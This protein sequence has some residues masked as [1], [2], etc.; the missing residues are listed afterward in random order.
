MESTKYFRAMSDETR[1][2]LLLLLAQRPLCVCQMQEILELPQS[3]ISKHL[4]KLRD[5]NILQS[6]HDGK[7]VKYELQDDHFLKELLV[8]AEKELMAQ[9]PFT[10]DRERINDF[11]HLV[12]VANRVA[13]NQ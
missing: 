8:L 1:L 2:R 11:D 12:E 13:N 5:Q 4:A 9:P 7:F 6:F 3:K 10:I